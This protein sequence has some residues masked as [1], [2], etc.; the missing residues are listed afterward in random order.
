MEI[1]SVSNHRVETPAANKISQ[2]TTPPA[3]SQETPG[4]RLDISDDGR[5]R[6]A[7][8]ADKARKEQGEDALPNKIGATEQEHA[9]EL[10]DGRL[11]QIR[12]KILSG[13]YDSAAVRD[14]IADRLT[15]ELEP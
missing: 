2:E 5:A 7:D 1:G 13:Y 12:L 8:M 6:L 9:L 15:E 3:S 11:E 14:S 10:K 4:D